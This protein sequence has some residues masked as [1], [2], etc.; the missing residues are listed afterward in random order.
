VTSS[1]PL[2]SGDQALAPCIDALKA[3]QT[4]VNVLRETATGITGKPYLK[5]ILLV[6]LHEHKPDQGNVF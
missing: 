6:S 5:R 2:P 3:D 4:K 1:T